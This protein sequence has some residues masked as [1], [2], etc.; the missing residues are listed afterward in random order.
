MVKDATRAMAALDL[1]RWPADQTPTIVVV[2]ERP[3]AVSALAEAWVVRNSDGTA[4]PT[5][6]VAGW[7]KLY[8]DALANPHASHKIIRL[9]GVLVHERV[10]IR[11]GPDE[12][13]AYLAQLTTLERLHA[14]LIEIT[15]VRRA[16]E[17]VRRRQRARQQ[18]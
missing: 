14:E 17:S 2:A 16:L 18:P 11:D 8:R 1:L 7:S 6:Y 9:A 12:E 3:Q 15:N 13:L 4:R 10:H 5:I